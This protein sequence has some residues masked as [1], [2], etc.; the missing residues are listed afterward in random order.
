[1]N[2]RKQLAQRALVVLAL[3]GVALVVVRGRHRE[4]PAEAVARSVHT[5]IEH[6]EYGRINKAVKMLDPAF[7]FNGYTRADISRGLVMNQRDTQNLTI[8]VSD[9]RVAV[10]EVTHQATA[11]MAVTVTFFRGGHEIV[12]GD[13]Q[14]LAVRVQYQ[15]QGRQWVAVRGEGDSAIEALGYAW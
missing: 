9:L 4:P 5:F 13:E 12:I 10:D 7:T 11:E 14:L 3:A 8:T 1:M 6:L 2:R 15:Q